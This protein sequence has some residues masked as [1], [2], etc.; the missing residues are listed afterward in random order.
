MGTNVFFM[1]SEPRL[2]V[3][4]SLVEARIIDL[5]YKQIS[6]LIATTKTSNCDRCFNN[7]EVKKLLMIKK[8]QLRVGH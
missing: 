8:S 6:E 2:G 3:A 7:S 4:F 1:E 5:A